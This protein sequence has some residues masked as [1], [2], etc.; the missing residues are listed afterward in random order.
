MRIHL[1]IA[2]TV[3]TLLSAQHL[4]PQAGPFDG[5][6]FRGRIAYSADGNHNDED[7]WAATPVALAIF[8]EAGLKARGIKAWDGRNETQYLAPL[9]ETVASGRSPA[10]VKLDFFAGDWQG[11]IDRVFTDFAY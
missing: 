8:A 11:D 3:L 9:H 1:P 7:D 10:D 4:L 2:G 5:Q 6:T